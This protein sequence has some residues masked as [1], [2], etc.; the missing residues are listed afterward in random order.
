MFVIL[1]GG[2]TVL[3]C[4]YP[5]KKSKRWLFAAACVLGVLLLA[6]AVYIALTFLLLDA[7]S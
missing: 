7:V 6:F 2:I 5:R 4:L 3:L 1:A